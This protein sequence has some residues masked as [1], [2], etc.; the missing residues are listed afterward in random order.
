MAPFPLRSSP[1]LAMDFKIVRAS[2]TVTTDPV[3]TTAAR[4]FPLSALALPWALAHWIASEI[5]DERLVA[6][7]VRDL[8][9]RAT[10]SSSKWVRSLE[11]GE[12][13]FV[14]IIASK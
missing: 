1:A 7:W 13:F 6:L 4:I 10:A 11:R 14:T 12:E 2:P 9:K 3:I 5:P 8:P